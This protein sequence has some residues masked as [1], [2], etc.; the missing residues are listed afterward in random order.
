MRTQFI[1]DSFCEDVLMWMLGRETPV[2][3]ER[4]RERDVMLDSTR[5]IFHHMGLEGA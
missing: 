2:D 4:G 5:N 1:Y 3:A